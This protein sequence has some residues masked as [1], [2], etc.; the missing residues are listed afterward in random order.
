MKIKEIDNGV[1]FMC[2]KKVYCGIRPSPVRC[3]W[4]CKYYDVKK[5]YCKDLDK[6][7]SPFSLCPEIIAIEAE[8]LR[9]RKG[10]LHEHNI[11][12]E[13]KI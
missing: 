5:L 13:I 8:E 1:T 4:Q 7:V 2:E 12:M 9:E 6:K 11:K 10:V 3:C